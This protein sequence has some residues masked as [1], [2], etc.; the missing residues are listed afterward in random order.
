MIDQ[1]ALEALRRSGRRTDLRRAVRY[2]RTNPVLLFWT[3][4]FLGNNFWPPY[5]PR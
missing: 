4:A 3:T 1:R 5:L 2:M